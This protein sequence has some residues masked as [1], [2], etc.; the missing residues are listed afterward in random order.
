M[1]AGRLDVTF[2]GRPASLVADRST[3]TLVLPGLRAALALRPRAGR[4]MNVIRPLLQRADLRLR[5]SLPLL[6][7]ITVVPRRRLTW[8]V[9]DRPAIATPVGDARGAS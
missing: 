9:A 4:L 8:L 3:L 1:V 6:P 7:A 5:V 2:D